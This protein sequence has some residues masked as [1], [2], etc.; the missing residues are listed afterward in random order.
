MWCLRPYFISKRSSRG[1]DPSPLLGLFIG[2][3]GGVSCG[4]AGFP[5]RELRR[6]F[7]AEPNEALDEDLGRDA[8]GSAS[9]AK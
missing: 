3:G 5:C 1:L 7:A 9:P 6:E 8:R 4:F 2:S